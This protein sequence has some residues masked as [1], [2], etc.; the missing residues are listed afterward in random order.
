MSSDRRTRLTPDQRRAQLVAS[1]VAFLAERSLDDLTME[2]LS[3]RVGVSR[4][5]LFHYFGSRQG[6]HKEVVITAAAALLAASVPRDDLPATER[7]TDTLLRI[8]G[9]VRDHGGTFYSLVRGVASGDP[10][11]RAEVDRARDVTAG[12][13]IDGFL[14]LGAEDSHLLRVAL[15]SWVNFAEEVLVELGLETDMPAG[16]IVEYLARSAYGVVGA[17]TGD[18]AGAGVGAGVAGLGGA[19]AAGG[20]EGRAGVADGAG[21]AGGVGAL[22]GAGS[23]DG[24]VSAAEEPGAAR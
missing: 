4:G 22:G 14:E 19:G 3:E 13:V 20:L 10:A 15:R 17:V 21:G 12:W 8:V 1:G 24:A 11:V 16:Q 2:I 23:A 5:L 6:L 9:F 18:A 7:L